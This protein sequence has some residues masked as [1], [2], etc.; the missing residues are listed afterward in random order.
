MIT[1]DGLLHCFAHR[2]KP[3]ACNHCCIAEFACSYILF[4]YEKLYIIYYI[5][6]YIYLL[7]YLLILDSLLR[8]CY[9]LGHWIIIDYGSMTSIGAK[10]EHGTTQVTSFS[11]LFAACENPL[12]QPP[13]RRASQALTCPCVGVLFTRWC[14]C[15]CVCVCMHVCMCVCAVFLRV[16]P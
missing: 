9:F 10:I 2:I 5:L 1:F 13:P 15:V 11:M 6:Y 4:I 16:R 12:F 14:V 3:P 7:I 8:C